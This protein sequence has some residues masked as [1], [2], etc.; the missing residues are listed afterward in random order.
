MLW[1]ILVCSICVCVFVWVCTFVCQQ[2]VIK[3]ISFPA[4]LSHCILF[5]SH[6]IRICF[7]HLAGDFSYSEIS[8]FKFWLC[9]IPATIL[10]NWLYKALRQRTLSLVINVQIHSF[11]F[12][13]G[14]VWSFPTAEQMS[15]RP[16]GKLSSKLVSFPWCLTHANWTHLTRLSTKTPHL[17]VNPH[18]ICCIRIK[19]EWPSPQLQGFFI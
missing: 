8:L 10:T 16:L 6:S 14:G 1:C 12:I 17:F 3:Y 5:F 7:E 19:I 15:P 18:P 4:A 9:F 13:W 11:L 2:S